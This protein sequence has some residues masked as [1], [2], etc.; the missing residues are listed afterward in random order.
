[1]YT[2]NVKNNYI[3][4]IT[5]NTGK[6]IAERGGSGSFDRQGSLFLEVPG[7]GSVNFLDLGDRKL[8]GY[9]EA[10]ETWG[11]LVRTHSTEAYYRY[12]GGGVLNATW[13]IDGTVTISTTTGTLMPIFIE[14]MIVDTFGIPIN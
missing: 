11:V 8:P 7:M 3:W 9:P 13:D 10:K 1:M 14:E 12:E 6:V 5:S 4:P 2:L